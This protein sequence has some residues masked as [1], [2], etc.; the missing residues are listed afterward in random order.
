MFNYSPPL[1]I[2]EAASLGLSNGLDAISLQCIS[3]VSLNYY[4]YIA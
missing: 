4:I 3:I 1:I 2:Y